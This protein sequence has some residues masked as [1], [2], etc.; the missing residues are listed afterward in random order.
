MR[1]N[2]I[3]GFLASVGLPKSGTKEVLRERVEKALGGGS[4][5]IPQIVEYLDSV[6]PWGKQHVYLYK[7]P[8]ASIPTVAK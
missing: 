6:V 8:Q 7:G 5:T 4:V 2:Q 3:S 1:K